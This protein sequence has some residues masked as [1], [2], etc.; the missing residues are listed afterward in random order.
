VTAAK[1]IQLS[2]P[3]KKMLPTLTTT[4]AS[5]SFMSYSA[6][7]RAPEASSSSSGMSSSKSN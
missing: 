6:R 7:M 2:V 5:V 4:L 1:N 3:Q